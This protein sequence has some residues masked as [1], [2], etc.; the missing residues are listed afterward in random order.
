MSHFTLNQLEA[1]SSNDIINNKTWTVIHNAFN[2]PFR[3]MLKEERD[4]LLLNMGVPLDTPYILHV[5]T[6]HPRKNRIFLLEILLELGQNWSGKICFAGMPLDTKLL[7]LAKR[8][9]L[10]DK[11]ISVVKPNHEG[12]VALYSGAE[13]FVFPSLSEGFG[14]PV[15]EAQ[16]CGVPVIAS[17]FEP[18]PEVSG[19]AAIHEQ[20]KDAKAYAKAILS[21]KDKSV[22]ETLIYSGFK[23]T[24]RFQLDI[25]IN[26]YL[27]LYNISI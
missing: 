19:G 27:K 10:T 9:D 5:G 4:V 8:L 14:W 7:D 13:A 15:I 23:N 16:A 26:S 18:M 1:L 17:S 6:A 2:A 24:K 20:P 11:I 3:P 12:L 22:Q 25:M 21:L